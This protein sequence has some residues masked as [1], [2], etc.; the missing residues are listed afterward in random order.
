MFGLRN[1]RACRG[2]LLRIRQVRRRGACG[3]PCLQAASSL[4]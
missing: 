4:A 3:S 1:I 2:T